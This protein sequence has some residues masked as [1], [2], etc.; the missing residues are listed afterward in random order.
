MHA[1]RR[2]RLSACSEDDIFE[3]LT[4]FELWMRLGR[5]GGAGK[6][7]PAEGSPTEDIGELAE[8]AIGFDN[9]G[10]LGAGDADRISAEAHRDA[11]FSLKQAKII[12][13][14]PAQA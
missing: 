9:R 2:D 10:A 7:A 14:W 1:L 5:A 12:A 3:E 11:E 4:E 8:H 13:I 6:L